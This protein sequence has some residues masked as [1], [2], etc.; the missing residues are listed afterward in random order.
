MTLEKHAVICPV[1]KTMM[2]IGKR[3][4][5][6]IIRDLVSGTK[7]FCQ[8]EQSLEG[9]SPKMLSQRLHELE[10]H[11]ILKREVFPEV[12]VRVEYSLTAKGRDLKKVVDSM[13]VW[14][15]KWD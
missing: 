11:G 15:T 7:R 3:W 12:P 2:V 8:L 9:I 1:H 5:A 4:T 14:G 13:A 10:A 6:L